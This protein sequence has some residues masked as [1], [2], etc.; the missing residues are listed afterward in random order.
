MN[1]AV[2]K[3]ACTSFL[4]NVSCDVRKRKIT[5]VLYKKDHENIFISYFCLQFEYKG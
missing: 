2:Q 5:A 3:S 4:Q 1:L